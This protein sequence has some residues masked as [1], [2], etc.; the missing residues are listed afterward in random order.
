M[1]CKS[2]APGDTVLLCQRLER[3]EVMNFGTLL[4]SSYLPARP[5]T[6]VLELAQGCDAD[7]LPF[8]WFHSAHLNNHDVVGRSVQLGSCRVALGQNHIAVRKADRVVDDFDLC[9][10]ARERGR[11]EAAVADDQIR[12]H[13][14]RQLVEP[15]TSGDGGVNPEHQWH[16][17]S[18]RHRP[19]DRMRPRLVA[20]DRIVRV[21]PQNSSELPPRAPDRRWIAQP[22]VAEVDDR[23]ALRL[24]LSGNL[25]M[26]AQSHR[27]LHRRLEL[28]ITRERA[29]KGLNAP[30]KI[31]AMNVQYFQMCGPVARVIRTRE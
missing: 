14:P 8:Q 12:S 27:H 3:F 5:S 7:T 1:P 22:H 11:G 31:A 16:S 28:A 26:K 6:D 17:R 30:V 20:D 13:A 21:A 23:H 24:K 19:E 2:D 29:E 9:C 10:G 25:A 18:L 4:S 15:V